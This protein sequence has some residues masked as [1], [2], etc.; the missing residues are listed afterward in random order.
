VD[1]VCHGDIKCGIIIAGI[2]GAVFAEC[3]KRRGA[4]VI[5]LR[6]KLLSS[7]SESDMADASPSGGQMSGIQGTVLSS[8]D[9]ASCKV[10]SLSPSSDPG[11]LNLP[12]L[13]EKTCQAATPPLDAS[14]DSPV[15]IREL[16]FQGVILPCKFIPLASQPACL[17]SCQTHQRT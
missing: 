13:F 8:C 1:A 16:P 11:I 4:G 10:K 2:D 17:V 7:G 6:L 9:K 15:D 12:S 14:R 5:L 3:S